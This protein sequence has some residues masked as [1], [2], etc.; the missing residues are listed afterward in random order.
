[1]MLSTHDSLVLAESLLKKKD[2][3]SRFSARQ[4]LFLNSPVSKLVELYL[5]NN[6]GTPQ[7]LDKFPMMVPIYNEIPQRLLL[8][9]S[10]KTLKSTLISNIIALD[11]IRY[12]Y[13]RMMYVSP[14]EEGTKRFS[15]N[16]LSAR[17]ISP[18]L[19]K[20]ISKLERNDVFFKQVRESQSNIILTYASDDANRCRGPSCSFLAVDELQG[21]LWDIIPIIEEVLAISRIKREIFSGTPLTT[22]NTIQQLWKT[23]NQMEWVMRC[24][25]CAHWNSL[26]EDNDPLKMIQ[27]KGLCC[28]KCGTILNSAKGQWVDFNPGE[29]QTMGFHLAQ[30]IIPYYNEIHSEWLD[31]YHKCY[32]KGYSMLQVYNEVFGLAY[33]IG[34]KPITEEKLKS[35]CVLGDMKDIYRNHAHRY[36]AVFFGVDWGVNPASSRTVGALGGIREDGIIEIFYIRIFKNTD[37]EEQIRELAEVA[38][39]YQPFLAMDSGPDPLRGKMLG[40]LYDP[41]KSQLVQYREGLLTQF[42]D[43]PASAMDWSQTRWCLHRSD[44]MGFTMELLKKN[45]ILFPRWEDSSEAM[46]DILSIFTEVKEDHLR[47]KIF[48]RHRDPDDFFHVLNYIACQAHLWGGNTFFQ[49]PSTSSEP[50]LNN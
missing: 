45:Q 27:Y 41:S 25:S 43:T 19:M 9:C 6:E 44:T 33:D 12:N 13:Y 16:Y 14:N 50:D 28:S 32:T 15:H 38:K 23:S 5:Y 48:Y 7:K 1:M 31:V 30:P 21:V 39:T 8:K 26:T 42:T 3:K 46:Q 24:D 4:L 29:R 40:N 11:L 49:G 2:I 20:I 35:L 36:S 18:P 22:D 34:S 37:Y 47:A 10:R 17:F